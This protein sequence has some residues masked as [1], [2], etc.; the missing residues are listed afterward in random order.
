MN[1]F[2]LLLIIVVCW[3]L[4]P[5]FKKVPLKKI[6]SKEFYILNHIIYSIPIF[7]YVLF[8]LYNKEFIFLNKLDKRDFIYLVLVVL[9]GLI[10]GLVF[11]E[12]LK[13][14]NAS[15]VIPH[16]QPLIIVSTLIVGYYLFNESINWKH[17][18]GTFLVVLGLVVI[19][20]G[21]N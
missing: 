7:I 5:F 14:N 3:T 21:N 8:M 16:I 15:Y 1:N 2:L 17:I 6:T 13:N 20:S 9:V 18:L 12:L 19:N 4:Q 10:G 11:A